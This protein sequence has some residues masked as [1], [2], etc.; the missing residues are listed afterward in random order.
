MANTF[1][2]AQPAIK[3][4]LLNIAESKYSLTI[5]PL[6]PGYGYTLGNTLRRVFLSSIPG[7]AV[8]RV[9]INDIT[10]EYQ[11]IPGVVEDALDLVLNLKL[12]R[13]RILTDDDRVILNLSK[14]GEGEVLVKDFV[15]G[16]KVEI[17]NPEHYL[18]FLNK[19]AKLDIEVEISRGVGYLS[20]DEINLAANTN[21]QDI[22][23]DATFSPVTNTSYEVEQVRVG[24][25][26][27][28]DKLSIN[29][30]TDN[31]IQAENV[32]KLALELVIG[33][34]SNILGSLQKTQG[35]ESG[36][37]T[38]KAPS[39][40]A[41]A[42]VEVDSNDDISL[43]SKIKNILEK[44]GISTNTQLKAR[45]EEV[46]SFPGINEKYLNNIKEYL[47]TLS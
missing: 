29:F 47:Q 25:K 39:S 30:E 27:N 18:C 19:D 12:L 16:G 43:T 45:M 3:T 31:S 20:V 15:T 26:T 21:P 5:E 38:S 40:T 24:D 22:Y 7:F 17:A 13:C 34:F 36:T 11:A 14:K 1:V 44:N 10:H 32:V 6:L 33:M 23:V 42:D 37:A 8:T 41:Q 35:F 4:N 9:K 46:E 28:Y 2:L